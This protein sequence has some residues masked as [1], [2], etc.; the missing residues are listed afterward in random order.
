[1]KIETA[2]GRKG[3]LTAS[4]SPSLAVRWDLKLK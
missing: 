2:D 1:M 4:V 3:V